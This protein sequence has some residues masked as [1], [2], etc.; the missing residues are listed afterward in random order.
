VL[1]LLEIKQLYYGYTENRF[2]SFHLIIIPI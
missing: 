1:L 2:R